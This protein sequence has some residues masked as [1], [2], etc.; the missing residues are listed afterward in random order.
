MN[1]RILIILAVGIGVGCV[2]WIVLR[3]TV[4]P[5]VSPVAQT[6]SAPTNTQVD[7]SALKT[8][9]EAGDA[10]AQTSLGWIYQKGMGA[11]PDM[12]EAVK[13]FQKAADQNYP[14]ALVAL[15][16]MTQAGQGITRNPANAARLY[17]SAAE[18]GSVTGEYDLAYLYEQGMGV[19]K[20]ET[21]AS[22]WYELAASGGDPIAQY[23]IGQRYM[24]GLGVATNRTQAYKWLTLAAAQGQGDSKKLLGKLKSQMS[25]DE[26]IEANR[27]T[28]GFSAHSGLAGTQP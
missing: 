11:K 21:N 7:I 20:D 28:K 1:R 19:D 10:A 6:A 8:R 5:E 26:I 18:K 24:L 12:K 22:K 13:W 25:S 9:A 17:Q 15:G 2:W 4:H 14:E 23:D 16:E 3:L 27:L